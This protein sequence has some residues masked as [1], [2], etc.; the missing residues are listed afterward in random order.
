MSKELVIDITNIGELQFALSR[1]AN[2]AGKGLERGPIQI[3]LRHKQVGRSNQ[4]NRLMWKLLND[5]ASQVVW[6]DRKLTPDDWKVL[7][8]ALLRKQ[9]LVP[10]LD[11]GFVALG[12]STRRMRKDEFSDLIECIY[13]VGVER[14]V[15]W[16]ADT[17]VD[18]NAYKEVRAA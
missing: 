6:C 16:S 1:A 4:A 5:I 9:E 7:I 18:W 17:S 15:K 11:G 10:G 14:N 12:Y 2:A 13:S 3:A 8:T